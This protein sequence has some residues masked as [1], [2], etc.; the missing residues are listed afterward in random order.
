MSATDAE[1]PK[2]QLAAAIRRLG[3]AFNPE[4]LQATY[5]LHA[6]LQRR[7]PKEGV[8]VTRDIAYGDHARH[9]LDLYVPDRMPTKAPVVVYFHGGGYIAGER[10]ALPGLIYDNVPTFFARH[11]LIGVNA[12]YRLAP[13]HKWPAGGSDVGAVVAWLHGHVAQHGGDPDC[14]VLMGQ[15]AGATHVAT[16]T[17]IPELHGPAGPRI[18]GSIL[19][20]GVF[21]PHHPLYSPGTPPPHQLAYFGEDPAKWA[22]RSPINHVR[23]GHPPV[24]VSVTEFD[25]YPLQWGSPALAAALTKCDAEMPW[26]VY[27]RDQN[28]VSPAMQINLDFDTLGPELLT[29]VGRCA[30]TGV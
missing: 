20:S 8:V 29:F 25:P 11:G 10:S 7:A 14:I 15:S 28:H 17:F 26:F 24:F 27:A 6:P 19:L 5:D 3:R 21:A 9:R 16:W 18:A 2:A 12:T 4:I 13:E 22:E 30:G 23:P 1:T